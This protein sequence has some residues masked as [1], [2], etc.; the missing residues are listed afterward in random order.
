MNVVNKGWAKWPIYLCDKEYL[1]EEVRK[2][3]VQFAITI[4]IL[5]NGYHEK[6]PC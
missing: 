4:P 3:G 1:W 5:C 2:P 6:R